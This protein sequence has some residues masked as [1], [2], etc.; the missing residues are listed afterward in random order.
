MIERYP[1]LMPCALAM[2]AVLAAIAIGA[3]AGMA[4]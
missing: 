3:L 2:I 4:G 1:I